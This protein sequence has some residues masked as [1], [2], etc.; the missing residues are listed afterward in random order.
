MKRIVIATGVC[1]VAAVLLRLPALDQLL[2]RDTA[3]YAAIGQRIGFHTLP[4]RDL[5]DHKQPLVHWV[6]AAINLV[7]PGSLGAIRLAAAIPAALAAAFVYLFLD[8]EEGRVRATAAA[9]AGL[10]AGASTTLQGTDLNTEHLLVMTGTATVIGGLWLGRSPWAA[11]PFAVGLLGGVA[12]TSK[13]IGGLVALAALIP[14]IAGRGERRQSILA[15]LV[16]FGAGL[17]APIAA[18]LAVYAIAGGAGDLI[19]ANLTYNSR[20][21]GEQ[22]FSLR[23]YGPYSLQFLICAAVVAGIVRIASREGRDVVGWTFLAWFAGAWLGAQTSSR[24]FPHYYVTVITPCTALVALSAGRISRGLRVAHLAALLLGA[25]AVV[26]LALPVVQN[27]SRSGPEIALEV[28]GPSELAL[29]APAD[30][31]GRML[32]G[33]ARAGDRLYVVG[34]N[35]QYYWRSEL[36]SENRWLFDYPAEVAPERFGPDVADLCVR[37]PRFVVITVTPTPAYARRCAD[38]RRYRP[39]YALGPVTALERRP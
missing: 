1:L 29:W 14:L 10:I 5:F 25:G 39:I 17:A 7:A 38:P 6:Y 22:G 32:R 31:V 11:A 20:Y 26:A 21:V 4:Y 3:L 12:V 16:A 13:A 8:S 19:F 24:G 35:P 2:D 37:S 18:V 23:P 30:D 27:L 15:T 36:E 34:S 33:R 9:A 28:Y